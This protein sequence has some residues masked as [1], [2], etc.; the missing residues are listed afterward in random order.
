MSFQFLA[1]PYLREVY[2]EAGGEPIMHILSQGK[3][4]AR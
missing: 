3:T 2:R 4:A 1:V